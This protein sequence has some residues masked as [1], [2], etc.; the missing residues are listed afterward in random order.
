MEHSL[1][2]TNRWKTDRVRLSDE[3]LI[4]R[5]ADGDR[6]ALDALYLR[7]A[8]SLLAYL[9]QFAGERGQ[10]EEILQ[11]T[12]VAVWQGAARFERR[13]SAKTWLFGI[14]RRQAHNALRR[15]NLDLTDDAAL[16]HFPS[17]EPEPETSALIN[18][19]R[20][21]V[22]NAIA[23]LGPIQ[24]EILTLAFAHDLSYPEMSEILAV[25]V[26]TIKSRLNI[27]K[28]QLRQLLES[29]ETEP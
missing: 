25:P 29:V 27:A 21:A 7:H 4:A 13:S 6:P 16:E 5:V 11:D 8:S 19:D 17:G 3:A 9:L 20:E 22:A 1:L 14:A 2:V 28:R 26:G 23:K 15:R 24:R 18:A 10:A 12:F